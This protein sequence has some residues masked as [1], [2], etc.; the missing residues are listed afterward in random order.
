MGKENME[1]NIPYGAREK[2][3]FWY[4]LTW[5]SRAVSAAINVM[6]VAYVTFYCTD[7]LGLNATIVG[8]MLLGSKVIDAI[9]DICA[10]YIIDK[11]HTRIGK[12]RPYEVFIV[13][14]WI[15]TIMLF[16]TPNF[17][18]TMQYAWTFIIY[19]LINAICN[20][21]LGASDSVYMA[22]AFSTDKNRMKAMSI[23]GFF[24]MI[25]SIV[26]TIIVPQFIDSAGTDKGAW[27][28]IVTILAIPMAAIGILR[29]I[30][31]KEIVTESPEKK[32]SAQTVGMKESIG[33]LFKN[34]YALMVIALMFIYALVNNL[35]SVNTYYF[36]YVIGDIGKMSL[37]SLTSM[38]TP[39]ILIVYP[40]IN[41]KL[42]SSGVLKVFSV[43]GIAGMVIRIIGGTNMVTIMIGAVG[44]ALANVPIGMMVNNYLIECMDYGEWKTGVRVE[45]LIASTTNF[46]NKLGGGAMSA[47]IGFIMG[48]AGYDG[49][50][51]VQSASA[52]TA[53]VT[54]FNWFPLI[55][56]V[57]MLVLALAYKMDKIR[58]QMM[59]DLEA[60]HNK[61]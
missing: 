27:T 5:S 29:F 38:I 2:M 60:K 4:S 57:I 36:K 42:G 45:G 53:I 9:T 32:E 44:L 18:I 1:K 39:F 20:T 7:V 52:M 31:V 50:L 34:K 61:A 10:G 13:G 6:L 26:F 59:A 11:T 14:E 56:F 37:M 30:F 46:A 55:L 35:G 48:A 40:M 17:G 47:V 58:P 28:S 3:P 8:T 23:N 22:R 12:A 43:A 25:L 49:T 15:L 51:A 33:A 41:R 16:A 24:V 54:L 19:I 21:A